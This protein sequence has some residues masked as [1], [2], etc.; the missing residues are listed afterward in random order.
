MLTSAGMSPATRRSDPATSHAAAESVGDVR[1]RQL[2]VLRVLVHNPGLTD[3]QIASNYVGPVQ[4]PSGLR[5]RRSEL[6][7][8]AL[9]EDSGARAR[10][11]SGRLAIVWSPTAEGVRVVAGSSKRRL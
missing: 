3:E 5:T 1:L 11:L 8:L 2:A 10:M 4:S 6:V 7:A 9:V